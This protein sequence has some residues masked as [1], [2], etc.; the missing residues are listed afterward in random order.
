MHAA[1]ILLVSI[2]ELLGHLSGTWKAPE[3]RVPKNTPLDVQVFGAGAMDVR[4]VTLVITPSGDATL[5]V[6]RS[7]VGKTGKVFAPSVMEVKMHIGDPVTTE[8]GHLR[9]KVD[10]TSAEERYLDGDREKWSRDGTRMS[11]SL[12]DLASKDLNMQLDTPDGRGAFGA[13]LT[14]ATAGATASSG[15]T[16]SRSRR[17][18]S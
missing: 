15:R 7:V 9:P 13:T 12:P 2:V 10:V 6:R 5:E 1:A 8:L 18:L 4:T 14:R 11:L 3:E 16:G 17:P